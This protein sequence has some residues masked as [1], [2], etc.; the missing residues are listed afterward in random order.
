MASWMTYASVIASGCCSQRL[1]LPSISVNR[2]VTVPDGSVNVVVDLPKKKDLCLRNK[3]RSVDD[4]R[5][6]D[7]L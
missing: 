2:V 1:V 6:I 5:V 3:M 7:D 4:A